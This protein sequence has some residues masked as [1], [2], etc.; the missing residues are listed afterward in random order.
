MDKSVIL[1][2]KYGRAIYEIAAEQGSLEKTE[3]E[4]HLIAD[5]IHDS[6]ELSNLLNHPMLARDVKKDT[7]KKLFADKVSPTVLQF[8]YVVIDKDRIAGFP[9]MVDNFVILAH[10]GLGM[11][12]AV[13]TSALPLSK[14]QAEHLKEK[15]AEMTGKK[16]LLKQKVDT[17]LLGGFTVQV[18]DRLIDGSVAR[19]LETLRN[20]IMQRD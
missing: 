9:A 2:K 5:A 12:E 15:L 19:Q 18:G 13:V 14:G 17:S 1:A 6:P 3:E 4:L 11:E 16:I 10:H 20:K 7:I 8:C